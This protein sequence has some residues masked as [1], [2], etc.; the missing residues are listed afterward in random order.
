MLA[1]YLDNMLGTL[2]PD[3]PKNPQR[4]PGSQCH[5]RKRQQMSNGI[6]NPQHERGMNQGP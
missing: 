2:H 3:S 6:Y 1:K 5:E 4:T